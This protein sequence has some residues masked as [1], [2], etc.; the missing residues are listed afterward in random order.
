MG[1]LLAVG[2]NPLWVIYGLGGAHND[3]IMTLFMMAAVALVVCEKTPTP[4]DS[5]TPGSS[6]AGRPLGNREAWAGASV[7]AAGMVKATGAALLPFMMLARRDRAE[8][9]PSA[10]FG[11]RT[12]AGAVGALVA[13][14]WPPTRCSA[15]TGST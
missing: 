4:A 2:A 9:A 3:L 6:P 7:V 10:R 5:A 12:L 13:I 15:S 1:A 14:A 8:H 11:Q